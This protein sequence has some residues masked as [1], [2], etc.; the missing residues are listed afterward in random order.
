MLT[1]F[2]H[3][4]IIAAIISIIG[5]TVFRGFFNNMNEQRKS[6]LRYWVSPH[7]PISLDPLL[8]DL[9]KHHPIQSLLHCTLTSLYRGTGSVNPELAVKWKESN[10]GADW[11]FEIRSDLTFSGGQKLDA[12]LVEQSLRRTFLLL[13]NQNS[14]YRFVEKLKGI[15]KFQN[16]SQPLEGIRV[17]KNSIAFSFEEPIPKFQEAISFGIFS[18][19]HPSHFD[20][21]T[22]AWKLDGLSGLNGCGPYQYL[23]ESETQVRMSKKRDYPGD[24]IHPH[25]FDELIQ[26][27]QASEVSPADVMNGGPRSE[28]LTNT[29]RFFPSGGRSINYF[30]VFSWPVKGG[31]WSDVRNRRQVRDRLYQH[32]SKNNVDST[33]SF[34]PLSMPGISEPTSGSEIEKK[35]QPVTSGTVVTFDDPHP[36]G[37]TGPKHPVFQSIQDTL[38][39]MGFKLNGRKNVTIELLVKNRD[40]KKKVF[41]LDIANMGTGISLEDPESDVRLMFSKEGID[42][43][44]PTGKIAEELK[45]SKINI[46]V[47][48][49][50]LYDDAIIWPVSI[51]NRGF[52]ARKD[53]DFSDYNTLKPLGELQWIGQK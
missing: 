24:L 18:I 36:E 5:L 3:V 14:K 4:S 38:L 51:S 17:E 44:D 13:K 46:Q 31:F 42:L 7:K 28:I 2:K 23:D 15:K 22:G 33:K 9:T 39:E 53:L 27:T 40:P 37:H 50:Q 43:P 45:K 41:D 16:L 25:A 48:N 52:W 21:K 8:Y 11:N 34:F 6:I 29:H 49:Q 30:R 19:V 32:L 26:V 47:I 12:A 20:S 10:G 1:R 35:L